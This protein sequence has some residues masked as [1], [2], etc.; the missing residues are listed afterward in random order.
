MVCNGP[1]GLDDISRCPWLTV[2]QERREGTAGTEKG[3][4]SVN[5]RTQGHPR[6]VLRRASFSQGE[7]SLCS[8]DC[9]VSL[10]CLSVCLA[11]GCTVHEHRP[12]AS[13]PLLF[14]SVFFLPLP[15]TPHY[16]HRSS[17]FIRFGLVY[18]LFCLLFPSLLITRVCKTSPGETQCCVPENTNPS[19]SHFSAPSV[20]LIRGRAATQFVR[21]IKKIFFKKGIKPIF[22]HGAESLKGL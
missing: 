4:G 18:F 22:I 2:N 5:D 13:H 12:F 14:S 9:C 7:F 16:P 11:V 19:K 21:L 1:L 15:R 17:L 3:S 8:C 20:A 10:C 6:G